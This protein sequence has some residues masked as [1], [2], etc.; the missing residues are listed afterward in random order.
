MKLSTI[1]SQ[2]RT[3]LDSLY[4]PTEID[5]IFYLVAEKILKQRATTLRQSLDEENPQLDKKRMQ[6]LFDLIQLKSHK[7]VQYV[8]GETE[9][10]GKKFFL[11]DQVLIPRPETEELVEWLLAETPNAKQTILDIGTGSGCIPVILK[12][13]LSE[14]TVYALESS[15]QAM[16]VAVRNSSYHQ[17]DIHFILDDFL[18]MHFNSLPSLDLIISN[19]PYI[20][21]SE[22]ETMPKNVVN[23]E[24]ENALFVPDH[25]PL[26]FYKKILQL[27][28]TKLNPNG[29]IFVEINQNLAKETHELFST[30]FYNVE[31]KKDI[32]G[33]FRFIKS[34]NL[35][36]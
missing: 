14:A 1:K 25:D 35:K 5:T 28:K 36:L 12:L 2:Y 34:F 11:N 15:N 16:E 4:K 8:I 23:F 29:K 6:F 3:E 13:Y 21:A 20:A 22:K 9:F 32:S 10:F 30:T 27:A 26:L 17:T 33:N 7:P 24:P 19:P 18:K 31:T